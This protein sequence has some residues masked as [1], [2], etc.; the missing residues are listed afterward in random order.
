MDLQDIAIGFTQERN[1][2]RIV[3]PRWKSRKDKTQRMNSLAY[4]AQPATICAQIFW[5]AIKVDLEFTQY[6]AVTRGN[7]NK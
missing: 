6:D 4:T 5:S 7:I 1:E 2:L 3:Q